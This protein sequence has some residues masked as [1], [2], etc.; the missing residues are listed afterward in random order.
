MQI[1]ELLDKARE[2]LDVNRVF[3]EP[4]ERNGV[5]V[6]PVARISGGGGSGSGPAT[7][8]SGGTGYGFKAEPAGVYVIK[9]G[10]AVW[11]P[12]VNVNRIVAGALVVGVIAVIRLPRVLKQLR[13]LFR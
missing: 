11:R 3:G 5:T 8:G 1:E 4:I 12:A 2:S 13:K 10:N 9:N 7:M 6:I